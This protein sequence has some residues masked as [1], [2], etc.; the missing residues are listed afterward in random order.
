VRGAQRRGPSGWRRGPGGGVGEQ[1]RR[2]A[3]RTRAAGADGARAAVQTRGR[4]AHAAARGGQHRA[5]EPGA[6]AA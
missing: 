4:R 5:D 6:A 1:A 2:R 3:E